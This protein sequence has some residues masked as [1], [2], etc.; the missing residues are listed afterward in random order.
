MGASTETKHNPLSRQLIDDVPGIGKGTR[1]PV[2]LGHDVNVADVWLQGVTGANTT[3]AIVDDGLD[4]YSDDLA[5]NYYAEGSWDFNDPGPEP[6]PRLSDDH[7]GMRCSG[8]VAAA[9][10]DVCGV[11]VA[12]DARIAGLRI[13]SKLITDADEALAMIRYHSFYP[14][15]NQG[16]YQWMMNEKDVKMLEAVKAFNPYDLYS[17]SDDVPKAEELKPYYMELIKE[18]FP[19]DVVRW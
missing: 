6:R 9:R 10:N 2:E 12:F 14:W 3:V 18:Y 4:M 1:Q 16:A 11:G 15:H 17:K 19:N 13:L 8:E 5:P 7:H